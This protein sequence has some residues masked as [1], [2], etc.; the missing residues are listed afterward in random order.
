M[1]W[2][3]NMMI[4]VGLPDERLLPDLSEW[5]RTEAPKN[6]RFGRPGAK[7]VGT[8]ADQTSNGVTTW[9][10]GKYP[11]CL[12]WAGALNHADLPAILA[13]IQSMP[14][15]AAGAVQVLLMDQ[16]QSYFRLWMIRDG[17]MVQFAPDPPPEDDADQPWV[18]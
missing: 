3:A 13:K 1:S 17:K 11:E 4:S 15:V 18:Y 6:A 10:G 16:E 12:V 5:L 14:W 9:G 8:L 7:G 2:V